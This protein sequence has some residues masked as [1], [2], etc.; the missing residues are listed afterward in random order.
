MAFSNGTL[1][2]SKGG[3]TRYNFPVSP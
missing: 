2:I 3:D 1:H